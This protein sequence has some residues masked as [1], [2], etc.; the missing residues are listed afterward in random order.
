MSHSTACA[1]SI[2]PTTTT[3]SNLFNTLSVYKLIKILSKSKNQH[4][5]ETL[6]PLMLNQELAFFTFLADK[7]QHFDANIASLHARVQIHHKVAERLANNPTQPFNINKQTGYAKKQTLCATDIKSWDICN[8]NAPPTNAPIA[9]DEHQD[10]QHNT[11][12][13]SVTMLLTEAISMIMMTPWM[14]LESP[15]TWENPTD[16]EDNSTGTVEL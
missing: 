12:L 10:T 7:I 14:M 8:T 16:I 1:S 2:P 11:V 13:S 4:D 15:I 6:C 5:I 3:M 9:I